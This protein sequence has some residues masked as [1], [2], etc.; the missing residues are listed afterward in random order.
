MG[1]R[2]AP[3][4][5]SAETSE[6]LVN[7]R[8]GTLTMNANASWTRSDA[9]V[10]PDPFSAFVAAPARRAVTAAARLRGAVASLLDPAIQA[11]AE[12]R[13]RLRDHQTIAT[14]SAVSDHVLNDI[15]CDRRTIHLMA[16]LSGDDCETGPRQHAISAA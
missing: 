13:R 9:H 6:T 4:P 12:A 16:R 8:R 14:L 7:S 1:Q 5:F 11:A 3:G 2:K 10:A 15:G